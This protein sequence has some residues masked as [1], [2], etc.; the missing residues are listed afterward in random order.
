MRVVAEIVDQIAPVEDRSAEGPALTEEGDLAWLGHGAGD[1]GVQAGEWAHYPQAVRADDPNPAAPRL[2]HDPPFERCAFGP[3]LLKPGRD[4]DDRPNPGLDALADQ[5]GH[6]RRG[7]GHDGQVDRVEQ[8]PD[9]GMGFDP[10]HAPPLRVDGE[11]GP[12]ERGFYQV[13]DDRPA[14]AAGLLGRPDDGD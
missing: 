13:P 6:H 5:V 10:Q 11:D 3:D 4:D 14:D 12:A 1:R 2:F 9:A 7:R 8:I